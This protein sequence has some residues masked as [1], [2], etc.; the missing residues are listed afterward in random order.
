MDRGR[1]GTRDRGRE[2][3]REGGRKERRYG[4][5][6]G[7]REGGKEGV[8]CHSCNLFQIIAGLSYSTLATNYGEI[9]LL[10]YVTEG[11]W[12]IKYSIW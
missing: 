4:R 2:G 1:D 3:G 8:T 5:R 9:S 11:N 12:L 7:G 10:Y 6:E